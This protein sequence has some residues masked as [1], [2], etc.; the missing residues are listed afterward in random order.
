MSQRRLPLI[1]F[2]VL[3]MGSI[4]A[5]QFLLRAGEPGWLVYR[6]LFAAMLLAL[7]ACLLVVW[8]DARRRRRRVRSG[9]CPTC[10]YDLRATPGRCPECGAEPKG[11]SA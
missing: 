5:F 11:A 8:R 4:A 9:A 2:A 1:L 3:W 6:V 10:G 7:V